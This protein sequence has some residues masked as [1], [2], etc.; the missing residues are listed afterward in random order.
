MLTKF[1]TLQAA[2]DFRAQLYTG[3]CRLWVKLIE[4]DA[5]EILL[6]LRSEPPDFQ[7]CWKSASSSF[8]WICGA[9]EEVV[10]LAAKH[11]AEHPQ[12]EPGQGTNRFLHSH[13]GQL[14]HERGTTCSFCEELGY[15]FPRR[16]LNINI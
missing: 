8:L 1:A 4:V 7:A 15:D 12:R 6:Q 13:H 9:A 2:I 11:A 10:E 3:S 14:S 16:T 5:D